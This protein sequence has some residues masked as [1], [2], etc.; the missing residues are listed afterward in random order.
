MWRRYWCRGLHKLCQAMLGL[1]LHQW[2]KFGFAD[3]ERLLDVC[4][5]NPCFFYLLNYRLRRTT[6]WH[7]SVL[8]V[9]N[10]RGCKYGRRSGIN[11]F[12]FH[13]INTFT[14]FQRF[15]FI[16][17]LYYLAGVSIIVRANISGSFQASCWLAVERLCFLTGHVCFAFVYP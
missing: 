15:V 16:V 5:W 7:I 12:I 10:K 14:Q 9:P 3:R 2:L 6:K 17:M 8:G 13:T 11:D 1:A 4:Q